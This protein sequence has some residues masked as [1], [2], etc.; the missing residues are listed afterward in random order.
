MAQ[1]LPLLA[2]LGSLLAHLGHILAHLGTQIA[3]SCKN[4]EK[5]SVLIGFQGSESGDPQGIWHHLGPSWRHLGPTWLY[6]GPLLA[7]LGADL[8]STCA[9]LGSSWASLGASWPHLGAS[10]NPNCNKL[11]KQIKN[12]CFS[13]FLQARIPPKPGLAMKRKAYSREYITLNTIW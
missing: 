10:W 2:H 4:I 11:K 6:L 1:F 8:G 9:S 13:W 7:H 5:P 3:K 12:C